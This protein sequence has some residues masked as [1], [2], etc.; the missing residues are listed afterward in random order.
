VVAQV[1]RAGGREFPAEIIERIRDAVETDAELS[2][3]ELS[4]QV[5][6]WLSWRQPNGRLRE[7]SC[8]VALRAL[9]QRG[10]ITLPAS[11]AAGDHCRGREVE[12]EHLG[13]EEPG[14]ALPTELRKLGRIELVVVGKHCPQEYQQW[15]R[16]LERFHP[17]GHV[18]LPQAHVRYLI[19]CRYGV[20]GALCFSAA[21]RHLA[22]RDAHIGW[23]TQ[24]RGANRELVVANSRFLLLPWVHVKDLASH[25]LALAAR[26]VAQDWHS[27]CG[28]RPV[29]LETYVD[30]A[31][32]RATCYRAAGWTH[33][34]S[35]SGRT[36]ND[37]T[38]TRPGRVRDIYLLPL[39]GDYRRRLCSEPIV[40]KPHGDPSSRAR[41]WARREL[42]GVDLG[43]PRRDERLVNV[44]EDF[45]ARPNASVPQACHH[46]WGRLK[47]AYRLLSNDNV[48]MRAI[49]APHYASTAARMHHEPVVLAVQDTT[50]LNYSTHAAT[51]GLGTITSQA[52][53]A[54]GLE[55]HDT[56]AFTP[57]GVPLGL[58]DVQVWA[59]DRAE[60]GKKHTR[61]Q[62]PIEHKESYKWLASFQAAAH[63]Q[64]LC[65]HTRVVSIGDRESDV[66]ELFE[67][68]LS[69]D[70]HPA[71][72]VRASADRCVQRAGTIARLWKVVESHP[73]SAVREVHVPRTAERAA[74]QARLSVRFC[75]VELRPPRNGPAGRRPL[76]VWAVL[77]R[78]DQPPTGVEPLEWML[79]TTIEVRTCAQAMEKI[80]WYVRRWGI[81][82]Y[83]HTLK[84]GCLIEERE[85]TT[86]TGLTNCLAIDMIVAWRI[87]YLTRLGR[88][89]PELPCTAVFT[90]DEWQSVLT[91]TH[92]HKP[93]PVQPPSLNEVIRLLA[94]LGGHIGRKSD[95]PPGVESMWIGLMRLSDISMCW[96]LFGPSARA[97]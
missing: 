71:L 11:R 25:V 72:L 52:D 97:P 48:S 86:A 62:R 95:G 2:R 5:C 65:P 82:V 50:S 88:E 46:S 36:R 30:A 32:Y 10:V 41:S 42:G 12:R 29:L 74:R 76:H 37:R 69:R 44:L 64:R 63:A 26:Q 47:G 8:R 73:A 31:R 60:F 93:L 3:S 24:A 84:S 21:A 61:R 19:R 87:L 89:V 59:R 39:G 15:K 35:T 33:V 34:G 6:Q 57:G 45:Y 54:L 4:R 20:L 90:E 70:D 43:D 81:E 7:V 91:V 94:K 38:R 40:R 79:L 75:A 23:S 14:V 67:L 83:H 58:V 13:L 96:R 66:F 92:P 56:L 49:L 51:T 28:L 53:G 68:A 85:I 80:D 55:V 77:A 18:A 17:E 9:E 1:V 16:A 27:A 78:E 22:A